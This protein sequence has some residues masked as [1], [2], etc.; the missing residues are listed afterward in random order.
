ML[1]SSE[2]ADKVPEK[3]VKVIQTFVVIPSLPAP[4]EG[5][6]ELAYNLRWTW[7]HKTIDLFRRLDNDLWESSGHNP[8]LLLGRIGQGRLQ[9]AAADEAFLA[10]LH[11]VKQEFDA[12]M[13][14]EGTWFTRQHGTPRAPLAAYFSAEFGITESLSIFAGGLGILAGD[15]LKSASDLGVPLVGVGLLYQQASFKQTLTS[16]GWQQEIYE[17]NDFANL[18]LLQEKHADQTSLTVAVPMAGHDVYAQVWRAQVGRVSLY[19]LDTNIPQ[20]QLAEDRAITARLYGGDSETRLRQELILGVGGYRALAELG[21]LPGV[22]HMNEGHSAFLA[23]ERVRQLMEQQK[24]SF[25][26]SAEQASAGLIFTTHTPVEAGH[27]YFS[28]ALM[29]SYLQDYSRSFGLSWQEF[30]ALGRRDSSN[31]NEEFCMTAL[32]L[33]LASF[34]NAVSKLHGEVSR[35]M[36]EDLWPG[37][38]TAE[39]P[40]SHVTNGV[41]FPSWVSGEMHYLYD[42]YLGPKWREEP[43]DRDVWRNVE[44]I[45]AEEL[46]RNHERRRERL[47]AFARTRLRKQLKQRGACSTESAA[48]ED[49]L[50]SR[51]LTIGF[52]RRFATYKR[53]NLF[54]QDTDRLARILTNAQHPV[55]IIMAGKAHPQDEQ[56]KEVIRRIVDVIQKKGLRTRIAFLEDYDMNVARYLVQGAD[57]WLNTPLRPMEACG[58]SG[59]KAAANGVLNVSTL[60]GWWD[61]AWAPDLP[62]ARLAPGWA[63]GGREHFESREYQ[64]QNEA[65]AF[66]D[67]LE[68]DLVPAFYDRKA[69]GLPRRWLARMQ[70]AIAGL[71]PVYNSH[72]MVREYVENYYLAAHQRHSQ[73][74]AQGAANAKEFS[75]WKDRVRACWPRIKVESVDTAGDSE[76]S[77]GSAIRSRAKIR[78]G[79]L[80]PED[81]AVELYAGR[82]DTE[83]NITG[84]LIRLME[85]VAQEGDLHV[86]ETA[87][88]PCAE[89]G[90]Y[91]YTV[92]VKPFHRGSESMLIPGCITWAG[93]ESK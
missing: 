88:E 14:S 67:L 8:V 36:W 2:P 81:V 47:V 33:R 1:S 71:C 58:T 39:T 16:G 49:V 23:L 66:Y 82:L 60:D 34:S 51:V 73:L 37:V 17:D 83:E 69:D 3:L 13:R 4:L 20:N 50:D 61:E 56:G 12:Y 21:I 24:L 30:L 43:A 38:P 31:D 78:L 55:Q 42:R 89:S 41:H 19:L 40:I 68:Q 29:G 48:C 44:N 65:Q 28:S 90:R 79:A 9:R 10:H 46:W 72:R 26:E 62:E 92:R 45:P 87:F 74:A 93:D 57:I 18:L 85:A 32:A 52:A 59:M 91:G 64:N 76:V 7:S 15:H 25:R 77:V 75:A 53:A 84:G 35:R 5:L 54:L 70:A 6:R 80:S 27:D 63:I 86:F 22:F 11:R